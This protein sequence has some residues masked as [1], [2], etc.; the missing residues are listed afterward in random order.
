MPTKN[1]NDNSKEILK[2]KM[3]EN[4]GK[5]E[6]EEAKEEIRPYF[7]CDA[8]DLYEKA[9]TSKARYI[10]YA[11]KDKEG[12]RTCFANDEGLYI[13]IESIGLEEIIKVK[14]QIWEKLRGLGKAYQKILKREKAILEG[15]LT[16]FDDEPEEPEQKEIKQA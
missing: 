6:I 2:I 16:L 9:L 10:I 13:N 3:D 15:Q 8:D 5:I 7:S 1:S 11:L 4:G 14:S 12:V